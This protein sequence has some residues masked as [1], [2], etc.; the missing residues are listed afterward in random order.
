MRRM[1]AALVAICAA[2]ALSALSAPAW[3][4]K[5]TSKSLVVSP[6]DVK[7]GQ[8]VKVSGGGC[9][10]I[11]VLVFFIDNKEFHRGNTKSGDWAYQVKLPSDLKSGDHDMWADCKGSKHKHAH[12]HVKGKKHDDG[13]DGD[14]KDKDKGKK[15][16]KSRRSFNAYPDVVIAGDK[17]WV[18]GTGCKKY[19]SV[20]IKFD[21][22][23][24]KRTYA[25]KHGT[26]DKGLRIPRHTKH[27]RHILS[28]KCEGRDLGSDGIKVKKTYKQDHDHMYADRSSVEAGKKLRL[29]GDDC[30]DG[31]PVATFDGA[32]VALNVTSKSKGFTA[33][34]TIPAGTAPGKHQLYAGCDAGSSSTTELNVLDPED[35]DTAAAQEAFGPQPTSDVAMWV[36]LFAGLALLVA[37][38]VLTTRRRNRA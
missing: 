34:A 32:P 16:K 11:T 38:V 24:V 26:F 7:A 35:T 33:E 23:T 21:G 20:K 15:H 36:G 17:V 9:R 1:S 25:D 5:P 4:T 37:S 8:M 29:R 10:G 3:A 18:E 22:E 27:G 30:P 12:F 6:T 31:K 14:D 19:A 13:D 2:I 28:G